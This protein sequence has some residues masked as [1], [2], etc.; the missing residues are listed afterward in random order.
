MRRKPVVVVIGGVRLVYYQTLFT[1]KRVESHA[2][3]QHAGAGGVNLFVQ[4]YV[5]VQ[6]NNFGQRMAILTVI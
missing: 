5:I 4:S 2:K 6:L 3:L 1:R